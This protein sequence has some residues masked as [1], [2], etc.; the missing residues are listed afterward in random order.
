MKSYI[1]T[2]K[3]SL[4]ILLSIFFGYVL[5]LESNSYEN[6]LPEECTIGVVSA[7][8]TSDGRPLLWKIRDNSELPNNE[9]VFDTTCRYKFIAVVNN[10]DTSVWMGV[11]AKGLAIV[12]S[13][14]KI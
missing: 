11:N 6:L 9:V 10:G 5:F 4:P 2:V 14:A 3:H 8:S 1:N 7:N 12:N 13:T